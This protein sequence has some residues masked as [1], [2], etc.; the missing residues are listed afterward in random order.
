MIK[1]VDED[2]DDQISLRE[3]FLIFRKAAKGEL[4]AQGLKSIAESVDVQKEG[5]GGAKDFFQA[6]IE[7]QANSKKAEEE[8]KA[9]QA[10]KKEQR[11]QAK[12]RKTDFK[13]K[14]AMFETKD[15]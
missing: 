11:E 7:N 15:S 1:E 12:V 4:S 6:K 10:D 14:A 9:E 3:F 13:N 5:V 8:I 2:L